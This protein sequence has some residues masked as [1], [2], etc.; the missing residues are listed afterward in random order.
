MPLTDHD[1]LLGGDVDPRTGRMRSLAELLQALREADAR[2]GIPA[3]EP[4]APRTLAAAAPPAAAV[5]VSPGERPVPHPVLSTVKPSSGP[6]ALGPPTGTAWLAVVGA[7]RGAGASTV[8]LATADAAA[9]A[10]RTVHLVSCALP[11]QCG[12]VGV[13]DIE[14]GVD[15]SG[16]WRRGRRGNA[17]LIDRSS[18]QHRDTAR[19]P[20]LPF[21]PD[22]T[23]VDAC[24]LSWVRAASA[25][26]R[27]LAVVL[28]CRQTV[29]GVQHAESALG[30]LAATSLPVLL[31]TIG[32]RRTPGSVYS[33][34]GPLLL[35]LRRTADRAVTV[36]LDRHL[37]L[38]GPSSGPLP[39][40]VT[41]AG[42]ALLAHL[43]SLEHHPVERQ[44][45][46]AP[47]RPAPGDVF[48]KEATS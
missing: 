30:E 36:P 45:R 25:H 21:E 11:L 41:A 31:A 40:P 43:D 3:S 28:V 20:L 2:I 29:P 18:G 39:R 32:P 15:D 6:D 38:T 19:W 34:T 26:A 16:A 42:R 4:R 35:E 14:L 1:V 10:G 17:V 47:S 8:A 5:S 12:L 9:A 13:P 33:A 24:D 44:Q 37:S 46:S 23:I 27:P 22:L 48:A 7:H